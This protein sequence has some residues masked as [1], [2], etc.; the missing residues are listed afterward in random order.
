MYVM[1]RRIRLT[2]YRPHEALALATLAAEYGGQTTGSP[3]HLWAKKFSPGVGTLLHTLVAP[4]IA[5]LESVLDKL[6][7]D[8][9][10]QELAERI[11]PYLVPASTD[12]SLAMVVHPTGP[13]ATLALGRPAEYMVVTRTTLA[14]RQFVRGLAL[15]A[16]L[17]KAAE[18]ATGV[19]SLFLGATTGN[20][21]GVAWA[22]RYND[23][24]EM[25]SCLRGLATDPAFVKMIDTQAGVVYT[26]VPGA[27]AQE[28]WRRVI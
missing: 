8:G 21:G 1:T 27:T 3:I 17:A 18:R 16:E 14:G 11:S 26:T 13:D 6:A 25:E 24:V 23:A 4:D 19:P 2:G 10:L 9:G 15:G 28:I 20:H 5:A 7:G 22:T 12:D